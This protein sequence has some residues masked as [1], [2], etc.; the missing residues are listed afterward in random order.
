MTVPGAVFLDCEEL[1]GVFAG[2]VPVATTGLLGTCGVAVLAVAALF[3]CAF[4]RAVAGFA[5]EAGWAVGEE[6][7]GV[8]AVAEGFAEAGEVAAGLAADC[9]AAP[10]VFRLE[11]WPAAIAAIAIASAKI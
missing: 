11:V 5:A 10:G 6:V 8:F 4:A 7:A 9:L 2:T 3:A 1:T